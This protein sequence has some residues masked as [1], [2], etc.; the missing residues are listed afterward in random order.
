MGMMQPRRV[1]QP[2]ID[3]GDTL[4]RYYK[5]NGP[6]CSLIIFLPLVLALLGVQIWMFTTDPAENLI[7]VGALLGIATAIMA[8]TSVYCIFYSPRATSL[9]MCK[10]RNSIQITYHMMCCQRSH[11]RS[12]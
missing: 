1:N 10:S 5:S 11:E 2:S 7:L 9:M 3:N 12:N 8:G 6:I 4:E